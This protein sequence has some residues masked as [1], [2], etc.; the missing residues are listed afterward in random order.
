MLRACIWLGAGGCLALSHGFGGHGAPILA[1]LGL[2]ALGLVLHGASLR[3][4]FYGGFAVGAVQAC[5]L[6]GLWQADAKIFVGIALAYGFERAI[7]CLGAKK[8]GGL[9]TY[10]WIPLWL[11]LEWLHRRVPYTLA[12][13]LG[14][15]QEGSF[16]LPL[17]RFLGTGS[18]VLVLGACAS[19]I[20]RSWHARC[21]AR[22]DRMVLLCVLSMVCAAHAASYL[23]MPKRSMLERSQTGRFFAAE[24]D[25]LP[26]RNMSQSFSKSSKLFKNDPSYKN[27]DLSASASAMHGASPVKQISIAAIQGGLSNAHYAR[28]LHP[29]ALGEDL[30]WPSK[31]YRQWTEAA[32]AADLVVWPETATPWVWDRDPEL[33]LLA[34]E[35]VAGKHGGILLGAAQALAGGGASNSGIVWHADHKPQIAIKRRLALRAESQFYPGDGVNLLTLPKTDTTPAIP[36]G[37]V[38]CLETTTPFFASELARKGAEFLVVLAEG[39]RFGSSWVGEMHAR[40][41]VMRA[42][43]SGL[44]VVHAGQHGLTSLI[45]PMG[46]RLPWGPAYR[47]GWVWGVLEAGPSTSFYPWFAPFEG[48]CLLG[49]LLWGCWSRYR[50]VRLRDADASVNARTNK[51]P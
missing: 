50:W 24:P 33:M 20:V 34:K 18:L 1:L 25:A 46:H 10:V 19:V 8:L 28:A 4:A 15:A 43:E 5:V 13:L 6:V 44:F 35:M 22:S 27:S 21:V 36:F 2:V 31:V 14:D 3:E 42:V 9:D 30:V 39:G 40:R 16:L 26:R 17:A 38:F 12:D 48:L 47:S 37:V 41:S 51:K 7:F 23:G 32:P 45:D 29:H 49:W 11:G